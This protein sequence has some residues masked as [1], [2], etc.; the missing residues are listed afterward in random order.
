MSA[1]YLST[2][3]LG[4]ASATKLLGWVQDGLGSSTLFHHVNHMSGGLP[5]HIS[6]FHLET[7]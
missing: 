1:F 4:Y 6:V 3:V 5:S 2:F 7:V